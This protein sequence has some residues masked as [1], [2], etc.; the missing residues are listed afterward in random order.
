VE[1]FGQKQHTST[2]KGQLNCVWD[3]VLIFDMPKMA[4][5]IF[6]DGVIRISCRDAN[7]IPLPFTKKTM[8][9][10]YVFDATAVYFAKDHEMY[11]QWVALMDDEEA[12]DVGV[13]GYLKLSVSI[14]G[15]PP[16]KPVVHDEELEMAEEKKRELMSGGDMTGLVLMPP[17]I[18]KTWKW[19]V[20]TVYRAESLPVMDGANLLIGQNAKTDAKFKVS[21]GGG[22]VVSTKVLMS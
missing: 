7:F 6:E 22:Q 21:F 15:P 4:K 1:C 19:A 16:D 5:E 11:R 20:V 2:V 10:A 17:T 12:D 13:Q 18:K 3:E 9:G 8:I 14:V